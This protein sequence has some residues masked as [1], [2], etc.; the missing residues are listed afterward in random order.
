[1]EI[2]DHYKIF[3]D[4][5]EQWYNVYSQGTDKLEKY[6]KDVRLRS[7]KERLEWIMANAGKVYS[8]Q[9]ICRYFKLFKDDNKTDLKNYVDEDNILKSQIKKYNKLV[10][11]I[12]KRSKTNDTIKEDDLC[13]LIKLKIYI[14]NNM[15]K[16]YKLKSDIV[17]NDISWKDLFDL[18]CTVLMKFEIRKDS[19]HDENDNVDF[20][21]ILY[22][23]KE[24]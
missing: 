14:Q 23:S 2:Y 13:D 21:E 9:A 22:N 5:R 8:Y 16:I 3:H 12:D 24:M 11:I 4:L 19:M 15:V 18:I 1:M 20:F 7:K 17:P 6:V 10:S